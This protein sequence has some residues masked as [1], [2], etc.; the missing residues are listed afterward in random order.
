MKPRNLHSND[1]EQIAYERMFS[2]IGWFYERKEGA[3]SAF[4]SDSKRWTTLPNRKPIDFKNG[5]LVKKVD[6]EEVAQ[7]WLAFIGFSEHAV[8]QKRYLFQHEEIYTLIFKLRTKKHGASY[9]FRIN[10]DE[11]KSDAASKSPDPKGLLCA[12]LLREFA[13]KAVKTRR[14]NREE[15]VR[16]LALEKQSRNDQEAA[17][18]KDQDY[19]RGVI[20]R[21]ML[22][23]FVDFF[24]YTMFSA[25]GDS[26]HEQF[27]A[28]LKNHSFRK[29]AETGDFH[30]VVDDLRS[31]NYDPNDVLIVVWEFY[32]HCVAQMISGAWLAQWRDTANRSK[33]IYGE[34]TRKSL[35]AEVLNAEPIFKRGMLVRI[36]TQR[37]NEAGGISQFL[38]QAVAKQL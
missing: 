19:L 5:K 12:Y 7:A 3:W 33:F 37:V 36:W 9:N 24:G 20:L 38:R 16:R 21:G 30:T 2:D 13:L 34:P 4:S 32:N 6:N 11:L 25:F 14:E 8:D 18:A 23:L 29:A 10:S 35:I 31:G 15:S 17:L 28:L 26:V 1:P 22:Q 27:G